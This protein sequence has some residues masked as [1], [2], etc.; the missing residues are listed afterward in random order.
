MFLALTDAGEDL[1]EIAEYL[2][3][4]AKKHRDRSTE[5]RTAKRVWKEGVREEESQRE[6]AD[7][8][9]AVMLYVAKAFSD[10]DDKNVVCEVIRS[11]YPAAPGGFSL[12]GRIHRARTGFFSFVQS[13]RVVD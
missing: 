5:T 13:H 12:L 7:R 4:L 11:Q 2:L 6:Q 9:Y 3:K 1:S 8:S 10:R